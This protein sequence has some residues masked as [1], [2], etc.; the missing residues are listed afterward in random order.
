VLH[1]DILEGGAHPAAAR[2]HRALSAVIA[3]SR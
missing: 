3:A 1:K 2:L